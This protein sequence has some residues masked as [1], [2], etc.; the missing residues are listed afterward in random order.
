[1][2]RVHGYSVA[3][4]VLIASVPLAFACGGGES[5][6]PESP[7][8]ESSASSSSEAPAASDSA[9]PAE[10]AS[11]APA[12]DTSTP[13]SESTAASTPPPPTL[14]STDCGKC[15]DKTCAKA[16]AACGKNSDCQST[17]DGIHGCSSG[18]AACIESATAPTAAKP[19]KLASA[20]EGCAKRAVAKACKAKCQ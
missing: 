7:A 4:L 14:E 1:M 8:G 13:S 16:E 18:A 10:S 20:F 5:K 3:T 11:A 19:K 2:R 15:I 9:A 12:A 17:L 6:P